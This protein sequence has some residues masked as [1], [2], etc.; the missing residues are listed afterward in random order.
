[1]R[2]TVAAHAR[3]M[4]VCVIEVRVRSTRLDKETGVAVRDTNRVYDLAIDFSK[5]PEM[6]VAGLQAVFQDGVDSGRWARRHG[7]TGPRS[8]T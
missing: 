5:P 3:G 6:I 1:M 7:D 2:I 4:G 8:A